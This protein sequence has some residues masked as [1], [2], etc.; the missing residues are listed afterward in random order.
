MQQVVMNPS[1]TQISGGCAGMPNKASAGFDV[2]PRANLRKGPRFFL[3]SYHPLGETEQGR[4]VATH[5]RI[6][7]FVDYSIR[8][9]PDFQN[10][11]P[12]VTGLCRCDMLVGQA[13][14]GDFIAYV[15]VKSAG[16]RRLVAI[17]QVLHKMPSHAAAADWYRREGLDLPTNCVVHGNDA[18]P[19]ALAVP[20][21]NFTTYAAWKAGYRWRSEHYSSFLICRA[22]G[23]PELVNPP[24]VPDGIFGRQFPNTR[25][26]KLLTG[27]EF[28][29][30]RKLLE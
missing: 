7:P 29:Q 16:P 21:K 12:S 1:R 30:L 8:R 28:A 22:V 3:N 17:L 2:V 5:H 26:P 15:T 14:A 9:E 24:L 13:E 19:I 11:F 23:G 10:P 4:M 20:P 27:R 6:P 25:S 18:L